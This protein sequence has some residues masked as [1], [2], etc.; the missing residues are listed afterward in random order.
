MTDTLKSRIAFAASCLTNLSENVDLTTDGDH[1]RDL[2][3]ICKKIIQLHDFVIEKQHARTEHGGGGKSVKSRTKGPQVNRPQK[4]KPQKPSQQHIK[5]T[6]T[7]TAS[8]SS[9]KAPPVKRRANPKQSASKKKKLLLEPVDIPGFL[10]SYFKTLID[11]NSYIADQQGRILGEINKDTIKP[12]DAD[13][14]HRLNKL[15]YL[16]GS[17]EDIDDLQARARKTY[18]YDDEEESGFM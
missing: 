17:P 4:P 10:D 1:S 14:S 13:I 7:G 3:E 15:G 5:S 8:S 9:S 6:V 18:E 16:I 11:G 12:I 2:T